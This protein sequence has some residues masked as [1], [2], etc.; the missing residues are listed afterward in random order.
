MGLTLL[1][2]SQETNQ[3]RHFDKVGAATT[4]LV[5]DVRTKL[6]L[7]RRRLDEC[8]FIDGHAVLR[9]S[10]LWGYL[11]KRLRPELTIVSRELMIAAIANKLESRPE[12]WLHGP[13]AAKT[14]FE[15]I[16]QLL[17]ILISSGEGFVLDDWFAEAEQAPSRHRWQAWC[18]VAREVWAALERDGIAANVWAIGLLAGSVE[19]REQLAKVWTRDLV[20]DLGAQ[21]S[22]VEADLLLD[23]AKVREVTV[24]RPSPAW[25]TDFPESRLAADWMRDTA[26][27]RGVHVQLHKLE[28]EAHDSEQ[29]APHYLRFP[30]AAAEVKQAVASVRNWLDAG[31][32]AERIAIAAPDLE[33]YWPVLALHLEC[34]GI[35]TSKSVVAALHSFPDVMAWLARLRSR[36][37]FPQLRD[38]EVDVF[39][40][41]TPPLSFAEFAELFANI[42]DGADLELSAVL[43]TF[44]E[45]SAGDRGRWSDELLARDEFLMKA[46][47]LIRID[48]DVNRMSNLI[49]SL[50]KAV[51]EECPPDL[52]FKSSRW[53]Q[54]VGELAAKTEVTTVPGDSIGV[55]CIGLGALDGADV[56]HAVVIGLHDG[57]LR[58]TSATAIQSSDIRSIERATGWALD[59]EDRRRTEFEARWILEQPRQQTILTFADTDALGTVQTPSWTWLSGAWS[60]TGQIPEQNVPALTRMDHLAM[61][62]LA[63]IGSEATRERLAR[64]RGERAAPIFGAGAMTRLSPSMVD[65]I[66]RCP[67]RY[68]FDSILGPR[69]QGELD[70][71]PAAMKQGKLQHA[72]LEALGRLQFV[73]QSDA[74]IEAILELAKIKI[75]TEDRRPIVRTHQ[76]W[77]LLRRKLVKLGQAVIKIERETRTQFPK[78]KTMA[79]ELE[80]KGAVD[81]KTG[82]LAALAGPDSWPFS[83]RIDRVDAVQSAGLGAACRAEADGRFVLID[84]KNRARERTLASWKSNHFWQ[85]LI[86]AMALEEGLFDS[87][88]LLAGAPSAVGNKLITAGAFLFDLTDK[89]KG[90]G[91]RV[92]A[93]AADLFDEPRGNSKQPKTH[94]ELA[95]SFAE[96]SARMREV[97]RVLAEGRFEPKP[98]K[99][100]HCE[101]C[102]WVLACRRPMRDFGDGEAESDGEGEV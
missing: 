24:F 14:L 80:I 93:L 95:D 7:Q 30:S 68:A 97:L 17:P 65:S 45:K 5:S 58:T 12:E 33:A 71:D 31:V 26:A 86:Y 76:A 42:Y 49:V 6:R 39:S 84:Y 10:E 43:M 72:L 66:S 75:E 37:S 27:A 96:A 82:A 29:V 32:V 54:Y 16:R 67:L 36:V 40:E 2:H 78:I 19:A 70:L 60:A 62:S 41:G 11:L 21:M 51:L 25:E 18:T 47:L 81:A 15:Y 73:E 8:G 59:G 28:S 83:G 57:A 88:Q 35:A 23:I 100:Q 48:D 64:D 1:I 34:E 99:P 94:D 63:A 38:L 91:L 56:T 61:R 3:A 69:F 44:Y 46:A 4:W 79:V 90:S 77:L 98:F 85:L 55:Q 89:T 50:F 20:V 102:Q 9:A 22:Q 92:A 52:A 101:T 87:T 74:E 53:V 13:G